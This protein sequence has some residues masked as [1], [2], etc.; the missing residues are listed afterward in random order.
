MAERTLQPDQR[1]ARRLDELR[2]KQQ[3]NTTF[4]D[5]IPDYRHTSSNWKHKCAIRHGTQ[6]MT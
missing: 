4:H 1:L 3:V 6:S 5:G 2:L